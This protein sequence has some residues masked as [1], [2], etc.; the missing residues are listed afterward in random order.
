ME[1]QVMYRMSESS[2]ALARKTR[3]QNVAESVD[4]WI[5]SDG[6][7]IREDVHSWINVKGK[8]NNKL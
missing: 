3:P 6:K 4:D 1:N 8:K 2:A 5:R 7:K